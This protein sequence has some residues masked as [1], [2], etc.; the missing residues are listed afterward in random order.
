MS[1]YPV[2]QGQSKCSKPP[3]P[4]KY[5]LATQAGLKGFFEHARF[6]G[7]CRGAKYRGQFILSVAEW[8]LVL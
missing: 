7:S 5:S 2:F 3:A 8:R 1:V 4:D 6:G